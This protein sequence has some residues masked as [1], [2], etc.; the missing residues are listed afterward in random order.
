MDVIL[1]SFG[2]T[3]KGDTTMTG[4]TGM[5]EL[6]SFSHNVAM[7]VTNDVSNKER[8]SG[9]PYLGEFSVSKFV[10]GT[11]PT[12]NAYCCGGKEIPT[13][14]I[15][16]ARNSGDDGGIT[17]PFI[18]YTLSNVY[19]ASISVSGGGG[20]P[21][22]SISLN[23]AKIKWEMTTQKSDGT[24]EGTAATSWDLTTNKSAT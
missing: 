24:K 23:F 12:L 19:I 1:L 20:K 10:D 22:E 13:A 14:T 9:K 16:C 8:T 18:T 17:M 4:F 15:I 6:M 11:T 21:S 5:I 2:D 3:I 7:Q